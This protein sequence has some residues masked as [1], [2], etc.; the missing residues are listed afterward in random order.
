MVRGSEFA[1]S[2]H[3]R[4]APMANASQVDCPRAEAGRSGPKWGLDYMTKLVIRFAR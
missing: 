2:T 1:L 4:V 3:A